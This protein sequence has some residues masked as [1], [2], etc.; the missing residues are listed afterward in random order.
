MNC[1]YCEHPDSKVINSRSNQNGSAVRRRRECQSCQRRFTTYEQVEQIP[2]QVVK[3]DGRR[4]PFERDKIL[5]GLQVACRKRN[6][7][8]EELERIVDHV[9]KQ[10]Q[11][12]IEKEIDADGI[13]ELVLKR[14]KDV[15]G[16]AYVRFA[17]V[18]RDFADIGEFSEE[19]RDLLKQGR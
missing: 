3:K 18:Y 5:R 4:E 13:G 6:V 9:E 15:D 12:S 14:L 10:V 16:V 17:S 7:P 2:T 19:V 1:P 8:F 11:N